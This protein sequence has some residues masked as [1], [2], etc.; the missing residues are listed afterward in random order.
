MCKIVNQIGMV[1]VDLRND[2]DYGGLG[3]NQSVTDQEDPEEL[4]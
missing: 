2:T 3:H 1:D 4:R